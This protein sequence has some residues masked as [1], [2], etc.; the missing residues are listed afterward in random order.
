VSTI[1]LLHL[2]WAW[3]GAGL[4]VALSSIAAE[5]APRSQ[6]TK[7]IFSAPKSDTVSSNL[8]ELRD[9]ALPFRKLESGLK[10]P[11]E[12]FDP[13]GRGDVRP[14]RA[15][16]PPP[17][18]IPKRTIKEQMNDRAEEMFLNPELFENSKDDKELF[19]LTE[20]D[21][22]PYKTKPRNALDRYQ[23][24]MERDRP[25]LTNNSSRTTD[26]F[27]EQKDAL[28]RND[29]VRFGLKPL[30]PVEETTPPGNQPP[31]RD[32][33]ANTT[34][35]EW[36]TAGRT[37]PRAFDSG[38]SENPDSFQNRPR[39]NPVETRREGFQ[40][41]LQD[42]AYARSG[43]SA[44]ASAANSS[45]G[46]YNPYLN[47][48]QTTTPP[49]PSAAPTPSWNTRPVAVSGA[50]G[51]S[52]SFSKTVGLVGEPVQP[53]PMPE[54]T[55]S[56]TFKDLNSAPAPQPAPAVATPKRPAKFQIPQRTY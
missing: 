43:A 33:F 39:S 38:L 40:R 4:V 36:N 50:G 17:Q 52:D 16:V 47:P 24:R 7:I 56:A 27:S 55:V 46:A 12:V 34:D 15:P 6:G 2:R 45:A 31:R 48:Y 30:N 3:L 53:K 10:K 25:G 11:F 49:R 19:G 29:S 26:L 28:D 44:N 51:A 18:A 9:P 21:V 32:A 20:E 8:S 13:V 54:F 37:V 42:P 5:E 1:S 35:Q 41:L 22:D 23:D 14:A